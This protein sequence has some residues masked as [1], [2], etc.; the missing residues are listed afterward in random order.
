VAAVLS[1]VQP[2][3]AGMTSMST[4]LPRRRRTTDISANALAALINIPTLVLIGFVLFAPILCALYISLTRIN[5]GSLRRGFPF[6]LIGVEN[7]LT[8]ISDPLFLHALVNTLIFAAFT[9]TTEVLAGLGIALLILNKSRFI[10]RLT[11]ALILLPYG[12]PYV[13]NGLVWGYIYN[14]QFGFLNRVLSSANLIHSPIDWL[15]NS[16]ITIFLVAI[17]Y[18]WRTL[19]FTILLFHAALVSLPRDIYEA[20]E[21]DG[22]GYWQRFF[23]ITL[24]LIRPVMGVVVILRTTF[25]F[26]VFDEVLAITQ[27]GPG[28]ATWVASWYA[29]KKSFEPPF[30]IG[31]GSAASFIIAFVLLIFAVIYTKAIMRRSVR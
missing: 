25:A 6:P 31:V 11:G 23:M 8:V 30:A 5:I 21:I 17:P 3:G 28:D 29:Y 10:A 7:Y 13:A 22:A 24:P 18:I 14:S 26:L 2:A 16:R 15:G 27:G 1:G 4:T 12:V 9:V 19:P 20:A